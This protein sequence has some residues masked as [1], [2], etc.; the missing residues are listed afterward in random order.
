MYDE[1]AFIVLY[2]IIL[3]PWIICFAISAGIAY[4]I[5]KDAKKRFPPN[6]S[7]PTLWAVIGFFLN[8][9]GL[10][11]YLLKRPERTYQPSPQQLQP[12]MVQQPNVQQ[13][14]MYPQPLNYPQPRQIPQRVCPGCGLQVD[15]SWSVCPRC[16]TRLK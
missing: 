5:Y 10:L 9:L 15:P 6:S 4:Y 2:L 8:L 7:E 13:P 14:Q 3:L 12:Q 1:S 11:I 16:G